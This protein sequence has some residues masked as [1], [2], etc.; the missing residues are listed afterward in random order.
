MVLWG[1][2]A[3]AQHPSNRYAMIKN[4]EIGD[5]VRDVEITKVLHDGRTYSVSISDYS[6]KLLILDFWTTGCKACISNMPKMDVLQKS[7]AGDLVVMAVTPEEQTKVTQFWAKNSYLNSLDLRVVVED[8]VLSRMFAH[9]V[10]PHLAWV[11]QGK[12]VALTDGE[13]A[14]GAHIEQV[15]SGSDLT[16]AMKRELLDHDYSQPLIKPMHKYTTMDDFQSYSVLLG[17]QKGL[18]GY[19]G[20]HRDTSAGYVRGTVINMPIANVYFQL[21]RK[22]MG[23]ERFF[24]LVRPDLFITPNQL[25]MENGRDYGTYYYDGLSEGIKAEWHERNNISFELVRADTG[26]RDED[27]YGVMAAELNRMLDINMRFERREVNCLVLKYL[28]KGSRDAPAVP[29]DLSLKAGVFRGNLERFLY[30][31]NLWAR[32]PQ[33]FNAG[34]VNTGDPVELELKST[35]SLQELN[36]LLSPYGVGFF[37]EP[38]AVDMLVVG[39]LQ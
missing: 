8:T 23:L 32:N 36:G 17:H 35:M 5:S 24:A 25:L 34:V 33:A 39:P 22:N 10:E 38:K 21:L 7:F 20:I 16:W 18:T 13:Y 30:E 19:L 12:L 9:F 27:I 3:E 2:A 29:V 14:T 31:I 26:Q 4:H 15:L 28:N 37:V 6:D 11:Y 1:S